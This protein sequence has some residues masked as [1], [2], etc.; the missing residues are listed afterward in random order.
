MQ[1]IESEIPKEQSVEDL[2]K[3]FGILA[4]KVLNFHMRTRMPGTEKFQTLFEE[5]H[6]NASYEDQIEIPRRSEMLKIIQEMQS[7]LQQITDPLSMDDYQSGAYKDIIELNKDLADL[8]IFWEKQI[9]PSR[10][11]FL[12]TGLLTAGA[13]FLG[14]RAIDRDRMGEVDVGV[15]GPKSLTEENVEHIKDTHGID[16]YTGLPIL[17]AI[18]YGYE[19]LTDQELERVTTLLKKELSK[20]PKDYFVQNGIYTIFC[21]KDLKHI[22]PNK[23]IGGVK[24]ITNEIVISLVN[25]NEKLFEVTVHHELYHAVEEGATIIPSFISGKDMGKTNTEWNED[26]YECACNPYEKPEEWLRTFSSNYGMGDPVEDRAT[27]AEFLMDREFHKDLLAHVDTLT[28]QD[29]VVFMNKINY[30]KQKYF[31]WSDGMMDEQYW[32]DLIEGRVDENYF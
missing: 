13:L 27:F 10:R 7:I 29:K 25:G 23:E 19:K 15:E 14:V 20:Y 8:R 28:G 16:I 17:H 18:K 21:V 4:R 6:L 26:T 9:Q 1:E 12:R 32:Q 11:E 31:E 2:L 22:I 5:L 3:N 24:L 30:I